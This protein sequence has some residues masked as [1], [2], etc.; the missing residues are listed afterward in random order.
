MKWNSFLLIIIF[1]NNSIFLTIEASKN[2]YYNSKEYPNNLIL[3]NRKEYS[4]SGS[5]NKN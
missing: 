4:E 3:A 5:V 1:T 2:T